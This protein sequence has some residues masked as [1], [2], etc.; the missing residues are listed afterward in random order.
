MVFGSQE[1]RNQIEATTEERNFFQSK[2]LEQVSLIQDLQN[3]LKKSKREITRLRQELM[4]QSFQQASKIS[5][6]IHEE[7]KDDNADSQSPSEPL[8]DSPSGLTSEDDD[9]EGSEEEDEEEEADL[10]ENEAIR[11]SASKLLQWASYRQARPSLEPT[12]EV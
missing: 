6:T 11:E 4:T 12:D 8:P 7:K 9:D 3:E 10:D 5:D 1:L 2:Y